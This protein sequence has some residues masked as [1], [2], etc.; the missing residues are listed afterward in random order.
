[1]L[2][3]FFVSKLSRLQHVILTFMVWYTVEF[4]PLIGIFFGQQQQLLNL[5]VGIEYNQANLIKIGNNYSW[6]NSQPA[7]NVTSNILEN[8]WV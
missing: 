7:G 6:R 8:S 3:D 2:S 4:R 1:M 5:N